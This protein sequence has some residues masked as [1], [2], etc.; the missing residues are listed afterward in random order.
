MLFWNDARLW[1]DART[2]QIL[3][4]ALF[5][6]VGLGTRDWTLQP[7]MIAVAIATCVM[8]QWVMI[9]VSQQLSAISSQPSAVSHQQSAVS[10]NS[11]RSSAAAQSTTQ[12]SLRLE[13]RSKAKL[14]TQ[15][16]KLK[17][18]NSKLHSSS[19]ILHPSFL[20]SLPSALVTS[21]GLSILIR[22]DHYSTMV[23]ACVAA[24]A[25]KFLIR[26][27][28]KH[29][30][31]PG[32]FGI[33]AALTLTPDAWVSPGQWGEE[34][35]CALMFL[36]CG[37]LVVGRVGRWDT[38]VAFLG[39]YAVLEAVRNVLL[40]WTWDV[41]VHRLMSGSLLMF[42]LFM[43][44][45]PRTIPNARI[46][47]VLWAMAIALLTFFLRN[48]LFLSTAVFW[49]LFALAPLSILID[50]LFPADRFVWSDR[51]LNKAEE[52]EGAGEAEAQ[53]V[54]TL[55]TQIS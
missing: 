51:F 31:N 29:V 19:L 24:I 52:T 8:T 5:L 41:W 27:Q 11:E 46:G 35:W 15:N 34:G 18:R 17:T 23:L 22:A 14:E 39:S 10:D 49:A 13:L 9:A 37:G 25:S 12:N 50:A 36:S 38:T 20:S 3:F 26:V 33:V 16:S 1:N 53:E 45:D 7:G 32:N 28:G 48:Y 6:I 40:G 54:T 55:V 21:L 44:T 43:I 2:Y 47:R 30:F 4:L 42:S